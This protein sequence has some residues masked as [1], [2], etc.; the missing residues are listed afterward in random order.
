MP[1]KMSVLHCVL[2]HAVQLI[3]T[4]CSLS[5]S[6]LFSRVNSKTG[7]LS[8]AF[9]IVESSSLIKSHCACISSVPLGIKLAHNC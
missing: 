8:L 3:A 9:E 4:V 6:L 1:L 5:L 7:L 2:E